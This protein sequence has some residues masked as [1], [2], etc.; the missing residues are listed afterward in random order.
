MRFVSEEGI[1]RSRARGT[2]SQE[3]QLEGMEGWGYIFVEPEPADK[4]PR[5]PRRNWLIRP[6]QR[7]PNLLSPSPGAGVRTRFGV[8]RRRWRRDISGI[9]SVSR[10]PQS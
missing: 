3:E 8:S 5:P 4:R 2:R 6:E 9:Q 7:P 10:R 1:T